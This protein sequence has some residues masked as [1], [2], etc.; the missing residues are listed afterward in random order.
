MSLQIKSAVTHSDLV[1]R[2]KLLFNEEMDV[3][4]LAGV[5][6][7]LKKRDSETASGVLRAIK[8]IHRSAFHRQRLGA[9]QHLSFD[10]EIRDALR[11]YFPERVTLSF[12]DGKSYCEKIRWF[13]RLYDQRFESLQIIATT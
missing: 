5:V 13:L 11:E 1:S 8:A 6:R 3:A 2:P 10:T 7:M 12:F 4:A 9:Y